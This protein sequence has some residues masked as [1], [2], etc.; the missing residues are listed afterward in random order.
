MLDL[1]LFEFLN[2]ESVDKENWLHIE[3]I[4]NS[5]S[6]IKTIKKCTHWNPSL[7]TLFQSGPLYY[8]PQFIFRVT[9]FLCWGSETDTLKYVLLTCWI[10]EASGLSELT[11]TNISSEEAEAPLSA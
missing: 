2:A 6:K 5:C 7:S 4:I 1:W 8:F 9:I 11:L 10:K 3:L